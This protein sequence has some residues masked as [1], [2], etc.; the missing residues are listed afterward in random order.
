MT[1]KCPKCGSTQLITGT[2]KDHCPACGYSIRYY[3]RFLIPILTATFLV[4]PS[5]N[6]QDA[7]QNA[8]KRLDDILTLQQFESVLEPPEAFIEVPER[9]PEPVPE[10]P[11]KPAVTFQKLSKGAGLVT[12]TVQTTEHYLI[13]ESWCAA[14]PAA[15]R[16][17]KSEGHPDSHVLTIKQAAAQFG[18]H[19]ST[20][21]HRFTREVTQTLINPATYRRQWPPEWDVEGNRNPSKSFLLSHL[22]KNKNHANKHW[23]AWHL[24]NW[25]KEALAAL[26]DDDHDGVVPTFDDNDLLVEITD[27]PPTTFN[28]LTAL[29]ESLLYSSG[30]PEG[31]T[32]GSLFE[33]E[34]DAPDILP[35]VIASLMKD[36][37]Y[38]HPSTGMELDWSGDKSFSLQKNSVLIKP[39]IRVSVKRLGITARASVSEIRFDDTYR[40]VTVVTEG[41]ITPDFTINFK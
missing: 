38:S 17:F 37:H 12:T 10:E 19:T 15:K 21:P 18:E 29:S 22:R 5:L 39:P 28:A 3:T 40:S 32:Y 2:L 23:Q 14:C 34:Y 7:L 9:Q 1:D 35:I 36:Q 33:V 20:V 27:T 11:A 30:P 6:A 41:V 13:S 16:R 31:M 26:H 8:R 4:C 24:E 25:S